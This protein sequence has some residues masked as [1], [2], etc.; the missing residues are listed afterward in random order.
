MELEK[1]YEVLNITSENTEEEMKSSYKKLIKKYHPDSYQ[2]TPLVVL[3]EEKLKEINEAY[4]V[5][6]KHFKDSGE[7]PVKEKYFANQYKN[8]EAEKYKKHYSDSSFWNKLKKIAKNAGL[9]VICYALTLYYI[10][11]KDSIPIVERGAI[12]GALGYFILPIDFIPD[13]IIGFGYIDDIGIMISAIK[14][15]MSYVDE[16]IKNQV[17]LKLNDWFDVDYGEVEKILKV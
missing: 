7:P 6:I 5:L 16:E 8:I 15:S 13:F 12:I 14:R 2:N 9:K 1:A 3:A 17:Y 4:E 10:L 11:Q